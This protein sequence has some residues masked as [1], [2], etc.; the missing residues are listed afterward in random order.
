MRDLIV[1]L[2]TAVA[3]SGT[4]RD[5]QEQLL[6]LV[7][8]TADEVTVDTLGNG[9]ARKR[10]KGPH[11]VLAAHADEAGVMAIHV[12]EK[13]FVRV[14]GVG[15]S[16]PRQCIGRHVEFTNGTAGVIGV[17]DGVKIEDVTFDKLYIDIGAEDAVE[18]LTKVHV[19]LEAVVV[20]PVV[21]LGEHRLAGRALDNR[22][23]C[24][25]AV[26]AFR[27]AAQQGRNVTLVFTAQGAVGA[28]GAKTAAYALHPDLALILDAA[29]AGDTPEGPR[30]ALCLG[31]G[32]AVKIMDRTAI[33][34]LAVKNHLIESAARAGVDIQYEVSPKTTSDAG[35]IQLSVDGIAIGGVSYP[36]RYAGENGT[37][38]DVRDA[39]AA[40]RLVVEAIQSYS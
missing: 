29:P 27:E 34:P 30:M 33:V 26:E 37:V 10:G 36:A 3:P 32:P 23:G 21:A 16:D 20:S 39:E 28:R 5:F 13:G 18:A 38:V 7:R 1:K 2:A 11:V 14:I 4:E 9:I 40:V 25:I 31:K 22:V 24:A 12:D 17:E 6:D 8:D 35:S 15:D 19:G